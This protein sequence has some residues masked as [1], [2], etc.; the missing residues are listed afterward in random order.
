MLGHV[1]KLHEVYWGEFLPKLAGLDPVIYECLNKAH[2]EVDTQSANVGF[3]LPMLFDAVWIYAV[4]RGIEMPAEFSWDED[5]YAFCKPIGF[6]FLKVPDEVS[7]V[8]IDLKR[9]ANS[10]INNEYLATIA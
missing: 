5:F 2:C 1:E 7:G 3:K 8:S 10:R 4:K 6:P 9:N